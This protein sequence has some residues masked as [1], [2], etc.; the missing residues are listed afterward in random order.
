MKINITLYFATVEQR[1]EWHAVVQNAI[2]SV[3][4]GLTH[5][6]EDIDEPGCIIGRIIYKPGTK[7]KAVLTTT[8]Y[9]V[10]QIKFTNVETAEEG[11][12]AYTTADFGYTGYEIKVF[13]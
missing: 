12:A 4:P 10:T 6:V 2:L 9:G 5:S 1:A 3:F 11:C 7:Y 13:D 8:K